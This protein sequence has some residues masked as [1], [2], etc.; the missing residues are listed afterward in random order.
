MRWF[1]EFIGLLAAI[2][3][4]AAAL[5]VAAR[6]P[7]YDIG[8]FLAL[9]ALSFV[10]MMWLDAHTDEVLVVGDAHSASG[11]LLRGRLDEAGFAVRTCAGPDARPC[12]VLRGESCP[13]HGHPV[14]AVIASASYAPCGEALHIG[15]V[16]TPRDDPMTVAR[17][18]SM[19]RHP[20]GRALRA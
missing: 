15:T 6:L 13:V 12:P 16:R 14:A 9:A 4:F 2:F 11:V 20:A 18:S 1:H 10:L 7:W 5:S 17:V 19:A 8:A 3:G